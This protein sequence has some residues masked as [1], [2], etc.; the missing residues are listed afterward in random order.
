MK[1][2]RERKGKR[3]LEAGDRLPTSTVGCEIFER[4]GCDRDQRDP[5]AVRVRAEI[6]RCAGWIAHYHARRSRLR[7]GAFESRLPSLGALLPSR[8]CSVGLLRPSELVA[9]RP[10]PLNSIVVFLCA[11]SVLL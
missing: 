10:L 7:G 11:L 8:L 1:E 9:G 5:H 2:S 6:H 4:G 3:D